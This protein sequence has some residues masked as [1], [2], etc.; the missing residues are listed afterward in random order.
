MPDS[1]IPAPNAELLDLVN[2]FSNGI[3]EVINPNYLANPNWSPESAL[4][5]NDTTIN[6]R[7]AP[8]E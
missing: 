6:E 2:E 8:K 1:T 7:L 3:I 4:T 5:E